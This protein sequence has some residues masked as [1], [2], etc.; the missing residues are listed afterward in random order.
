LSILRKH[1]IITPYGISLLCAKPG[2]GAIALAF[3]LAPVFSFAAKYSHGRWMKVRQTYQLMLD[4]KP[5]QVAALSEGPCEF[6]GKIDSVDPPL[7]SP[8]S[9]QECVYYDF[10]VIEETGKDTCTV[11]DDKQT[12]SFTVTDSSGSVEINPDEGN[13]HV[14]IDRQAHSRELNDADSECKRSSRVVIEI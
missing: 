8:W 12:Q 5:C 1:S 3:L 13:F 4:T 14:K 7:V 6:L 9:Q 2:A 10:I 11:F